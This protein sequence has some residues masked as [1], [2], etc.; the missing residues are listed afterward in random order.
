MS[1]EKEVKSVPGGCGPNFEISDLP[2]PPRD[3]NFKKLFAILGP[4]VIALGGTIGGG[5]WLVGPSLFVKW[6]LALLW[7][8]TISSTLQ[9]FLN[10]EMTRYTLYTG[11]PITVGFMRL[12]PGKA[13]W[14]WLFTIVGFCERGL[15]GWILACATAVVAFGIGKIPGVADKGTVVI[16]GFILFVSCAVVISLGKT[17][18]RTLEWANWIMMIVVLGGLFLLDL[19]IVPASIWWEGIKGFVTFGYVPQGVDVLL[20]GALVG[21]SAYGGFGNNAITNWYRDKGYGMGAK[22]G[23][24]P[25][26]IGGKVIHVSPHGKVPMA[27]EKNLYSWKGWWKLLDIDQF[28]VFWFGAMAGMFLPGILYV[29]VLPRGSSL[30][31]WG[32]AASS[33]SGLI[34]KL[35][36]FGWFLALFFGFWILYSTA[37]SNV[38]LVTRQCTDMLWFASDRLRKISKEDIR[39]IY[40]FL[41]IVFVIWGGL[42]MNITLPL[43][44]FAVSANIANFTMAL[45]AVAT[46][47]LNRK[48]LPK[49]YRPALWREIVLILN[50]IFFGFFFLMFVVKVIIPKVF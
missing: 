29:A 13:F 23:Y 10:L 21:Y 49:E 26:A 14:G 27:T 35:G 22:I 18:E 41:L 36:N 5:E 7:I 43:I 39:K 24:I 20:L 19:Y 25:A 46:I 38:D 3:L 28:A 6:G 12:K 9:V 2:E 8:T 11:E 44:I 32:I 16:W 42:F 50:L 31:S 15:P 45:S 40:Y 33:A 17:I 34:L 30:P 37:L 4:A 48:F 1:D 47:R